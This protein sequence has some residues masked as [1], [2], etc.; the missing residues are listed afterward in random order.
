MLVEEEESDKVVE[1]SETEAQSM[2]AAFE[3]NEF[4]L[5]RS[6]CTCRGTPRWLSINSNNIADHLIFKPEGEMKTKKVSEKEISSQKQLKSG[7]NLIINTPVSE[8]LCN[9]N[10]S[11][12]AMETNRIPFGRNLNNEVEDDT[13]P[14]KI[15]IVEAVKYSNSSSSNGRER[16]K[17]NNCVVKDMRGQ[18][19]V[20]GEKEQEMMEQFN[21][22]NIDGPPISS[23]ANEVTEK[24]DDNKNQKSSKQTQNNN[25]ENNGRNSPSQPIRRPVRNYEFHVPLEKQPISV[26]SKYTQ[27][28]TSA[29]NMNARS[30]ISCD[31]YQNINNIS[32]IASSDNVS[33]ETS[34]SP[35]QFS[36][37][38]DS[39]KDASNVKEYA[40]ILRRIPPSRLSSGKYSCIFY[41]FHDY[42][43]IINCKIQ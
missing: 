11:D 16:S 32:N 29:K 5:A 41:I 43:V 27:K 40:G 38:W 9:G 3:V 6:M 12:E 24:T 4:G 2:K 31:D 23:A 35:F 22:I 36:H 25:V 21:N 30:N 28:V 33:N 10:N 15:K 37:L 17:V 39:V 34:M 7:N 26:A 1:V 20:H 42:S 8:I 13:I 18:K 14:K 19:Q